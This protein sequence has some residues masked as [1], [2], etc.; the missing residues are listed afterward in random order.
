MKKIIFLDID[1][2]LN[3]TQTSNPRNHPYVV[4]RDLVHRFNTLV[5]QT[6]VNVVLISTWRLD[7]IGLLA[8]RYYGIPYIDAAP[9]LSGQ[10][11][12]EEV[13]QW[14]ERHL[15]VSRYAIVDDN[16]DCFDE[17]PLFQTD[18]RHGLTE[19]V[20][21]KLRLFLTGQS[22]ETFRQSSVSRIS[23][24]IGSLFDRQ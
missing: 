7:P 22:D 20:A 17:L 2:V 5:R 16:D 13:L 4:E 15:D 1:G 21:E 14:L 24:A 10:S 23:S 19:D 12:C 18:A 8:A 6:E 11:R 9:D 3:T